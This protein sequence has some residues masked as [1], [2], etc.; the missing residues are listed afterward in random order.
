FR[1]P[2][3]L[4]TYSIFLLHNALTDLCSATSCL[5]GTVRLIQNHAAD[6]M[7]IVFLGPCILISERLCRMCQGAFCYRLYVF[8]YVFSSRPPPS[9]TTI[10]ILC[11]LTYII[12]GPPTY[13]Y[14]SVE[15]DTSPE[16]AKRFGLEGYTT[17]YFFHSHPNALFANI[18]TVLLSPVAMIIIFMVRRKLIRRIKMALLNM[19][20]V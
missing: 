4:R 13:A 10:W 1:T 20:K 9:R 2:K 15:A 16:V 8:S 18:G 19:R 12:I 3:S 7:V 17:A 11:T 6:S 5:L 14:Y